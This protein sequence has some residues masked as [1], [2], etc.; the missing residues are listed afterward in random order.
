MKSVVICLALVPTLAASQVGQSG[1][2]DITVS[3]SQLSMT[4]TVPS[5]EILGGDSVLVSEEDQVRMAGA[6][7][8]LGEPLDLFALPPEAECYATAASVAFAGEGFRPKPEGQ[9]QA[10]ASDFSAEYV[11]EC[12]DTSKLTRIQF[13]YFDR[14]PDAQT[15]TVTLSGPQATHSH[16]VTRAKPVLDV[17][18]FR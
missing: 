18:A 14:F 7:S 9:A 17:P 3:G 11:V 12:Q 10:P 16:V 8:D 6:I 1:A 15:L 2:L 13:P 4:L 5:G